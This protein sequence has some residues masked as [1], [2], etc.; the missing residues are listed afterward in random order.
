MDWAAI[1]IPAFDLL[2]ASDEPIPALVGRAILD[3]LPFAFESKEQY[4]RWRDALAEGLDLDGRDMTLVGTCAT[5]RSLS[6]K[7][8]FKLFDLESDV[9]IAVVSRL[10]FDLAWHW[11]RTTNAVILNLDTQQQASFAAHRD[12]LIF[13][14]IVAADEFLGF[15]PFGPQWQR[16]MQRTAEL[17]PQQLRGRPTSIRIYRDSRS[18][19]DAQGRVL[20]SYRE[21]LGK[22]DPLERPSRDR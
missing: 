11:F 18:L 15:L 13:E 2:A 19:R 7:K 22:S 3:R 21:H 5:G 6:R 4:F 14:G 20:R 1:D 17:L 12:H 10:H 8:E 9:D 16:E